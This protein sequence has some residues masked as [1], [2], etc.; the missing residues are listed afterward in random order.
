MIDI[1]LYRI[2]I[3]TFSQKVRKMK[4]LNKYETTDEISNKA[5]LKTLLTVKLLLK[6]ILVFFLLPP[7]TSSISGFSGLLGRHSHTGTSLIPQDVKFEE[8]FF[9]RSRKQTTNFMAKYKYGNRE[10]V[11][12]GIKNLHLNIRSLGNKVFEVRNIIKEHSPHIFGLSE[13]QLK[14]INGIYDED[15]LKIPGYSILFPKSWELHGFARVLV[16]VKNSLEYE[17][18]EQL[19]DNLVQS[20]WLKASF[21]GGKKIYFCHYYRAL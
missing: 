17:H 20:V 7:S 2:R 21:K 9:I 1:N 18:I 6:I 8:Q 15:K 10:N 3:G 4:F 11:K 5:G 16:Y 12:K 19:E 14:K 13:C